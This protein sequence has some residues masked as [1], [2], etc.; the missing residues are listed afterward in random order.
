MTDFYKKLYGY[1]DDIQLKDDDIKVLEVGMTLRKMNSSKNSF[2]DRF[3]RLDLNN[4]QLVANTKEFRK[5][6]KT[7]PLVSLNEVKSG[8]S[9]DDLKT[10]KLKKSIQD[11]RKSAEMEDK[12]FVVVYDNYKKYLDLIAPNELERDRWV[13]VLSYFILLTKKRKGVLPETDKIM[14]NYFKLADR[15]NDKKINLN[16]VSAFLDSINIKLKKDKLKEMINNS[17]TDKDG[18]LNEEEFDNLIKQLFARK[19][20]MSLFKLIDTQDEP[21]A[22]FFI[23]EYVPLHKFK[24]FIE[25][26]QL[27]VIT[28]EECKEL[29]QKFEPNECKNDNNISLVGL[30]NYL[31]NDSQFIDNPQH[32][33][34]YQNMDLSF[35]HY[36]IN[37]SH[38][39]YLTGDQLTSTSQP[40]GYVAAIMKGARLLEMDCYDGSDGQPRIFHQKTLT[41]KLLLEDALIAIKEYAFKNTDY[42]L[43]ITIELHCSPQQQKTMAY[44]FEK[45]LNEYVVRNFDEINYPTLNQLKRKIV[46]R[47]RKPKED[48][49]FNKNASIK[50]ILREASR[51]EQDDYKSKNMFI[52]ELITSE[53][54]EFVNLLQNASFKGIDHSIENYQNY[55]T[56]S[57]SEPK[58]NELIKTEN[59]CRIIKYT[60]NFL[61]KVYP[62]W[63]RHDSS[64]F[65]P[66][67][68]WI[69]GFQ[70]AALNFQT[71]DKPMKINE[72]LFNDNG[73]CGFVL[74]PEILTN[75][76]LRFNPLDTSTMK[77]KKL[78]ELKVISAQKLPR[79][80]DLV[81]DIS[82]PYVKVSIY[83]VPS[84]V[85][86]E[87]TK[88]ITDNGFN[89]IWNEDFKFIVNCP[90]LAF[91]RFNVLD[92]DVG[93]DQ[94]IGYYTIRFENMRQ[95]YRH[96]RLKNSESKG[97]LFV[98]IKI[99]DI[100]FTV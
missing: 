36:F 83:G 39:T 12:A 71:Q 81:V 47:C 20:I 97:T 29:I 62:S 16:E 100:P 54:K 82:D 96:V 30:L 51:D 13:R 66:I 64:N 1:E 79:T 90:E 25:R 76:S 61:A 19:E 28:E 41:S 2:N 65:N 78:L 58:V 34:V 21:K 3:Y 15:S 9:T 92:E 73:R 69:Y 48:P 94:S 40:E 31:S 44:L 63:S 37:S 46:L 67:D 23:S 68:Y 89:P 42:P 53:L 11:K 49:E 88:S 85:A 70:I 27:E 77:N 50:G 5:T 17:D 59:P 60:S 43:I 87:R 4:N 33:K 98:G 10:Y 74:K 38:N 80:D 7:Y 56:S 32:D 6:E 18:Q 72:A 93:K 55:H 14:R 95:G 24:S 45:H 8:C 91:V 75:E 52:K 26:Y 99:T 84:D 35:K 22:K 86:E 57:L